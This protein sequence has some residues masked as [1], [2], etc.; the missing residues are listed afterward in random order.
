MYHNYIRSAT[1]IEF[2]EQNPGLS[3]PVIKARLISDV[4][5]TLRTLR[6]KGLVESRKEEKVLRWFVRRTQLQNSLASQSLV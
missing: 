4:G 3:E 5:Q 1:L 2:L 6:R